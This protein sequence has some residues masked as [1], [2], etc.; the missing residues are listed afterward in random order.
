MATVDWLTSHDFWSGV[1]LS[2]EKF[3]K[4]F[5]SMQGQRDRASRTPDLAATQRTMEVVRANAVKVDTIAFEKRAEERTKEAVAMP[6]NFK[7]VF[8][9]GAK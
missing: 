9:T 3:R 4:H 8:K 2:P 1:I 5:D 7:D 6:K